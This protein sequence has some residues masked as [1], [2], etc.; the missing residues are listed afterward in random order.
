MKNKVIEYAGYIIHVLTFISY[1]VLLTILE[2][3][4]TLGFLSYFGFL[5]FGL[6]IL[7][8][9]LSITSQSRNKNRGLIENSVYGVV[10]HPM[11]LGGMLLFIAMTLFL[12]HWIMLVLALVNVTIIYFFTVA[13]EK[14]DI[15]TFGD[16]YREY[17]GRVP[18][19]N[20]VIGLF[21]SLKRNKKNQ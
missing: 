13:E 3:P 20:L 10:R 2:G 11:Y 8:V 21:K 9:V 19:L 16:N 5:F 7:F 18:R 15:A 1:F 4:P 14:M 6:G 12:P 17:I